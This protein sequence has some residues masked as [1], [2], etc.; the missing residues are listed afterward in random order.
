[1]KHWFS[2]IVA[3]FL[4]LAPASPAT[5]VPERDVLA[6]VSAWLGQNAVFRQF[7]PNAAVAAVAVLDDGPAMAALAIVHLHPRGYV[8]MSTDDTLPPVVAFS[9]TASL[10]H[11]LAP[12]SPLADLLQAQNRRFADLLAQ[13]QT[14]SATDYFAQNRGQW[15]RLRATDQTRAAPIDPVPSTILQPPLLSTFWGQHA[16]YDHYLPTSGNTT[17]IR[18]DA[19][20]VPVAIAQILKFHHWPPRGQGG[21]SHAD[22]EG[23]TRATLAANL[24]LPFAWDAM[25]DAYAGAGGAPTAPAN[26]AVARACLA[27]GVFFDSDYELNGTG[28]FSNDIPKV[29]SNHLFFHSS[30]FK[31]SNISSHY[32]NYISP[33]ALYANI[34]NDILAGR[35]AYVGFSGMTNIGNHSFVADGLLTDSGADYYHFNYGWDGYENG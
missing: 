5:P 31:M 34:K 12:G 2:A 14:R 22:S 17:L 3:I 28:T 8:I 19:G 27:L 24:S 16:P 35:P 6:A 21:K 13:P 1:M 9:E 11:G 33:A 18:A 29:F 20:C 25:Q 4:C 26:L 30:D 23:A 10:T 32:S 7:A 15:D